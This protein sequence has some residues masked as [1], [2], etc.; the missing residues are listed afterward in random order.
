MDDGV[1]VVSVCVELYGCPHALIQVTA[2]VPAATSI[3]SETAVKIVNYLLQEHFRVLCNLRAKGEPPKVKCLFQP[4]DQSS[5]E[6]G[7]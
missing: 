2:S 4:E 5:V 6:A 3:R 7:I 1:E